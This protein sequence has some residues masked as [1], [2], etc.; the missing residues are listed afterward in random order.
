MA[1]SLVHRDTT[2]SSNLHHWWNKHNDGGKKK[3]KDPVTVKSSS[4]EQMHLYG[5]HYVKTNIFSACSQNCGWKFK[6]KRFSHDCFLD[7]HFAVSFWIKI[8]DVVTAVVVPAVHQHCVQDVVG[9]ILWVWLLEELIQ[10]QLIWK[11]KP[12]ESSGAGGTGK[13]SG[14]TSEGRWEKKTR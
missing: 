8:D 6:I 5:V 11:L 12:V 9:W 14:I 2:S 7:T 13:G 3:R 1:S 10:R 4:F